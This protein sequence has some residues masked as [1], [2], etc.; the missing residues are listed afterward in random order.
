VRVLILSKAFVVGAYQ[1]KLEE[2][3]AHENMDLIA[4]TPP[5]WRD[6]DRTQSLV[7]LHTRG[8]TLLE[9][10]IALNGRFHT[11]FYP[12]L[13]ALLRRFRPDICHVDEEAYNLST[14]L[15]VR[16]ACRVG[17]RT[18]FF[19]WQNLLRRYPAPFAAMER[20]VY[21]HVD[22][23]IA[24]TEEAAAILRQKGYAGT[25]RTIPQFGV[26]PRKRDCA[27]SPRP[28]GDWVGS[29]VC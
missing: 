6:G 23:A 9:T 3:A 22:A 11:H 25:L 4:I 14:F 18:L 29:G 27:L 19:S 10:P 1:T 2:L 20:Y 17:A 28:F 21:R 16:A 26:D 7:R 15:A 13:P 12:R 5:S 8:Y 24:G